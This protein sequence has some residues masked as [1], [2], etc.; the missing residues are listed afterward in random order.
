MVL[1]IIITYLLMRNR[2]KEINGLKD[3]PADQQKIDELIKLVEKQ[4][5]AIK[6]Y[7]DESAK[8]TGNDNT[9]FTDKTITQITNQDLIDKGITTPGGLTGPLKLVGFTKLKKIEINDRMS[10]APD[11]LDNDLTELTIVNC[12]ELEEIDVRSNKLTKLD[13]TKIKTDNGGDDGGIDRL[14]DLGGA[15][16]ESGLTRHIVPEKLDYYKDVVRVVREVLGMGPND[17]VAAILSDLKDKIVA[18]A[19]PQLQTKLDQAE[20]E[21]DAANAK[22]DAQKDYDTIKNERDQLKQQLEAIKTELGLKN[23]ATQQQI[24]DKIKELKGRPTN[25][26]YDAIKSQRDS[27]QTQVNNLQ[28]ITLSNEQRQKI[29]TAS[30]ANEV[31]TTRNEIIKS[32][33]GR[34]KDENASSDR[35][36]VC[37][38]VVA[39]S[40]LLILGIRKKDK[41]VQEIGSE[42]ALVNNNEENQQEALELN[43][44]TENENMVNPRNV[45]IIGITGH[46]KSTLANVLAGEEICKESAGGTSETRKTNYYVIDNIG[47]DDNRSRLSE[48]VILYEI[49]KSIY[50]AKE[51]IDQVFFVFRGKFSPEQ[52]KNFKLFEKLILESGI[53][54]FTTLV[55]SHFEDF[56]NSQECKKDQKALLNESAVIREIIESCNGI[57]HVDNPA[58]PEVDEDDSDNEEEISISEE[59]R[60]ESRKKVLNHLAENL[61]NYL[62]KEEE[63]NQS[64][65]LTKQEEL[66]EVKNKAI[67]EIKLKLEKELPAIK[68]KT[69][70]LIGRTGRGK[71][72]LANVITNTDDFKEGKLGVSE[73]K[74]IQ[75]KEFKNDNFDYL[76]IDNPG[77][78]DT[79]LPTEKTLDTIAEAVYLVRDGVN[80]QNTTIIRTRFKDFKKTK[81]REEDIES[82]IKVGGELAEII[83]S[84]EKRVIHNERDN[85]NIEKEIKNLEDTRK[86]LKEEIEEKENIIRQKVFAHIFNNYGD[87]E[88][89]LE[90]SEK[91][92]NKKLILE[93][94]KQLTAEKILSVNIEQLKSEYHRQLQ[95]DNRELEIKLNLKDKQN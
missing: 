31:E 81:K 80:Y 43:N 34:L 8:Y 36:N 15:V 53:T 46:G 25:T 21:R 57:I 93:D 10:G 63:I 50:A 41:S 26:D 42:S 78:G 55:H 89:V 2:E 68:T 35:L 29:Q 65:S 76:I 56:R 61:T 70:L 27:L 69:I 30:T 19:S 1:V 6:K 48:E 40:S 51:G 52:I 79:K 92:A 17:S 28:S 58:V 5:Q 82:M 95:S 90:I 38:G 75:T 49:G 77:I 94:N 39:I 44:I 7:G 86:E 33:F 88:K 54:K 4:N 59:R 16:I 24:I 47:F 20:Q 45:L 83:K 37:L 3:K 23:D 91:F 71:S 67:T 32:E 84:C 72:T 13:I 66:E 87:I 22:L 60:K 11:N 62:K 9:N 64:D 18:G 14:G 85:N 74:E 12:P 73:T